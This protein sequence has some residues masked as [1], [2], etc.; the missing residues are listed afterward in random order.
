MQEEW[1]DIVGYEGIYQVSNFGRI[2]SVDHYT[3]NNGRCMRVKGKIRVLSV[4][5][6]GYCGV[7]LHRGRSK[8]VGVHRLVA[9]AFI[10]NPDNLPCVNH[11]DENPSNNCIDNLEW[12][13][14][15]YNNEYNGRV[16]KCRGKISNT[17]KGRKHKKQLTNEQREHIRQGAI[18]GWKTRRRHKS[19]IT[20]ENS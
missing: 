1:K 5:K 6:K 15:K 18:N 8:F 19:A 10:P 2:K 7:V 14:Y 13:T 11:K 12:C 3:Y 4:N 20:K 16:E 17:L 9:Q